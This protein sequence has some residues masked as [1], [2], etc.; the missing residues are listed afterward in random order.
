MQI[1]LQ[2][3]NNPKIKRKGLHFLKSANPCLISIPLFRPLI[4]EET[5]LNQN[6]TK[7]QKK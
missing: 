7:N 2:K 6:L 5:P 3:N 1:L 4:Y